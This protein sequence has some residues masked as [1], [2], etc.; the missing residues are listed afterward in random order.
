MVM[1]FFFMDAYAKS[2][3]I[4]IGQPEPRYEI[5]RLFLKIAVSIQLEGNYPDYTILPAQFEN[6]TQA[7]LFKL[8][9]FKRGIDVVFLA[10]TPERARKARMI[11]IPILQGTIGYRVFI[12][13]KKY[14]QKFSRI[15]LKELKA[16]RAGAGAHWGD[17]SILEENGF[18]V[19][20]PLEKSNLFNM[21]IRDRIDYFPR[22]FI[23]API[24]VE[25]LNQMVGEE[26]FIV[27]ETKA[28]FYEFPIYYYVHKENE[29]LAKRIEAGFKK[30]QRLGI[31]K[32]RFRKY[33]EKELR[34]ANFEN[35]TVF[36]LPNT[37]FPPGFESSIDTSEW[38]PKRK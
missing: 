38:L 12:I 9:E 4:Y 2:N 13:D 27:E 1:F 32:T 17:T 14:K 19:V 21:L 6:L 5:R 7:R 18:N 24:E 37:H 36:R 31:I 23:E 29:Q 11:P 30:A 8:L 3:T 10:Y 15:T 35:K 26:R 25:Q 22:S 28:F 20:K 16:L 33:Y 34:E